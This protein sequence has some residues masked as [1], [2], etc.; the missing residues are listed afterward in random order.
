MCRHTESAPAGE[1]RGLKPFF[2]LPGI[3]SAGF[4]L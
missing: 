4:R 3:L 1:I 2:E